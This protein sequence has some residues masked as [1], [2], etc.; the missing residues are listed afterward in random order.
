MHATLIT[1]D[2][3]ASQDQLAEPFRD[4]AQALRQQ[5]GFLSK[6]WISTATGFGG[7]HLF[8]DRDAAE[9][10]LASE[11]AAGLMATEGF[12]NFE[13]THFGVLDELSAITGSAAATA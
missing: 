5:P 9:R 6:T 4:Y 8:T 10:Y 11:L 12:D 3:A 7:F 13:V 1:F 2:C